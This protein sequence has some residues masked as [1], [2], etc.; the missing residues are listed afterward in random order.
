M[1]STTRNC[2]YGTH[3]QYRE[4]YCLG[5]VCND[6]THHR[7][8]WPEFQCGVIFTDNV[9]YGLFVILG[10]VPFKFIKGRALNMSLYNS[11]MR[12]INRYRF[13]L[14]YISFHKS[15]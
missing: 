5:Q 14:N 6:G 9:R 1:I 4:L 13:V 11:I 3:A 8:Y 12:R 10:H 15:Q 7:A 2:Q